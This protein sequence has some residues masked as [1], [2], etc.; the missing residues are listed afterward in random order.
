MANNCLVTKLKDIVNNDSLKYLNGIQFKFNGVAGQTY[1]FNSQTYASQLTSKAII[2]GNANWRTGG[3][4]TDIVYY[5]TQ[6][7]IGYKIDCITDGEIII[8]I[9]NRDNLNAFT[10]NPG[11]REN[12]T[13]YT[14]SDF[15]T[16]FMKNLSFGGMLINRNKKIDDLKDC[17][18]LQGLYVNYSE[19]SGNIESLGKLTKLTELRCE[20]YTNIIGE[21]NTL[22]T[23]QVV[24]GRTNGTLV[25]CCN[26]KITLSGNV[27]ENNVSKTITF[28]SSLQNGYSIA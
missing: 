8:N 3:K 28:D 2:V 16:D 18:N 12:V 1:E 13:E 10:F 15:N 17:V 21:I 23:S 14:I 22:A 24:N 9:K 11:L 6:F 19:M 26:G 7:G 4:E 25:I 27:I 5:A 20:M